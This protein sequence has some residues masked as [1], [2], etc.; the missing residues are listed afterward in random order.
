MKIIILVDGSI[1][2][3][4]E[5]IGAVE[6]RGILIVDTGNCDELHEYNYLMSMIRKFARSGSQILLGKISGREDVIRELG[7]ESSEMIL[8]L[9]SKKNSPYYAEKPEDMFGDIIRL[10]EKENKSIEI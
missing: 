7:D 6:D 1:K 5:I 10:F 8:T 9:S 4:E 2:N 3:F